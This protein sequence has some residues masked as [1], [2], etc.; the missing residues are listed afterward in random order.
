MYVLL[1][2]QM[3]LYANQ[4]DFS[5]PDE[6]LCNIWWDLPLTTFTSYAQQ[7]ETMKK[8]FYRAKILDYAKTTHQCMMA[9]Q[10]G[11]SRGLNLTQIAS[12]TK[13]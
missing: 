1:L 7:C 13:H 10:F 11:A 4:L 5:H 3:S 9:I 8:G 6:N 2:R 12:F